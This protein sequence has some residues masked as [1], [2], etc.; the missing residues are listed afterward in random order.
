[1]TRKIIL[2]IAT[3]LDSY[4]ARENGE[5][6]WLFTDQEYGYGAFLERIDTVLMGRK[7]YEQVLTFGEYPYKEQQTYVFTSTKSG[8]DEY[9]TFI[10]KDVSSFVSNLMEKE[11]SDIW[12]VGGGEL[13]RELQKHNLIDEYIISIHPTIL[14]SG[15]PLFQAG[16]IE[17]NLKFVHME[18][19]SSGLVQLIYHTKK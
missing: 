9:A 3:S 10:N 2:Y 19:F 4:I 13:I 7:T 12:L 18:S 1:M 5:I 17:T 15:I 6:D 11:G 14:G 16:V 8:V